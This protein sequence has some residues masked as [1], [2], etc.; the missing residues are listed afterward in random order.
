MWFVFRK[1][2][3]ACVCEGAPPPPLPPYDLAAVCTLAPVFSR[4][5]EEAAEWW[6][7]LPAGTLAANGE[8]AFGKEGRGRRRTPFSCNRWDVQ[9]DAPGE[10]VAVTHNKPTPSH[11]T[12][13]AI[14]LNMESWLPPGC[15]YTTC[16][17]QCWKEKPVGRSR[18]IQQGCL[19]MQQWLC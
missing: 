17:L 10:D 13:S 2:V 7:C 18:L 3:I 15:V 9:Q 8:R 14:C 16:E 1:C 19:I 6:H 5:E 4:A 11:C 12:L